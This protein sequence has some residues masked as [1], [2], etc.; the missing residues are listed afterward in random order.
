MCN[1]WQNWHLLPWYFFFFYQILVFSQCWHT[2][3][4]SLEEFVESVLSSHHNSNYTQPEPPVFLLAPNTP[5]PPSSNS[6]AAFALEA[7]SKLFYNQLYPAASPAPLHSLPL[8]RWGASKTSAVLAK[9]VYIQHV[10][11]C[12]R[13][14]LVFLQSGVRCWQ[15]L[16]ELCVRGGVGTLTYCAFVCLWNINVGIKIALTFY[17]HR[18]HNPN[19]QWLL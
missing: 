9:C 4:N 16:S 14:C 15:A 11:V 2:A 10:C 12:M 13:V 3:L 6:L 18:R 1:L 7:L 17:C 19:T 5:P 8:F